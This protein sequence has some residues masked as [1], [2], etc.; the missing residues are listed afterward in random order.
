MST[1]TTAMIVIVMP[2][3]GKLNKNKPYGCDTLWCDALYYALLLLRLFGSLKSIYSMTV[4]K[5]TNY[6][7]LNG[8]HLNKFAAT[9]LTSSVSFLLTLSVSLHIYHFL[10]LLNK[11]S[12]LFDSTNDTDSEFI[13]LWMWTRLSF[14]YILCVLY[15]GNCGYFNS[16]KSMP[17]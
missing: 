13:W 3:I 14:V 9:Q 17:Q 1:T 11:Y 12:S 4:L 16:S 10:A 8:C 2:I 5:L 7:L 15:T 6:W